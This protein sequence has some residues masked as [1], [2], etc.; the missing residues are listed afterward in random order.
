MGKGFR[1]KRIR[2]ISSSSNSDASDNEKKGKKG[3]KDVAAPQ[4]ISGFNVTMPIMKPTI[5]NKLKISEKKKK[6]VNLR[7]Q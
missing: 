6:K 1:K 7:N 4:N 2:H 5:T 3:K